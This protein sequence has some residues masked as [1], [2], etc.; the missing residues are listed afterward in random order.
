[1]NLIILTHSVIIYFYF[2]L[3]FIIVLYIFYY[4]ECF[5]TCKNYLFAICIILHFHS[6]NL[7]ARIYTVHQHG[8]FIR[9][10]EYF[11]YQRGTGQIYCL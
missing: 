9:E 8:H 5:D 2:I 6:T 7:L 1:M 11:A 3:N 10:L 4:R